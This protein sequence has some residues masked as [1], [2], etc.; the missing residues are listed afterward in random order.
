MITYDPA[1]FESD[2]AKAKSREEIRD[3]IL[4]TY[5]NPEYRANMRA[6][7]LTGTSV[8]EHTQ[9]YLAA[10]LQPKN[11]VGIDADATA[12]QLAQAHN[13]SL[14]LEYRMLESNLQ[15]QT[16][17]EHLKSNITPYDIISFDFDRNYGPVVSQ[18]IRDVFSYDADHLTD[19]AL[20]YVGMQAKRE[21]PRQ[22]WR[23]FALT[24]SL[25]ARLYF[26]TTKNVWRSSDHMLNTI[27]D[28]SKHELDSTGRNADRF[29]HILENANLTQPPQFEETPSVFRDALA[30]EMMLAAAKYELNTITKEKVQYEMQNDAASDAKLAVWEKL[31]A[32]S[33]NKSMDD[34]VLQIGAIY[35]ASVSAVGWTS[36]ER[37]QRLKT[38][39]GHDSKLVETLFPEIFEYGFEYIPTRLTP[40]SYVSQS[41]CRMQGMLAHY[42]KTDVTEFAQQLKMTLKNP[43]KKEYFWELQRILQAESKTTSG[44][45][46]KPSFV[47]NMPTLVQFHSEGKYAQKLSKG[48]NLKT[49]RTLIRHIGSIM[50]ELRPTLGLQVGEISHYANSFLADSIGLF[51]E[52][53]QVMI[54]E[55]LGAIYDSKTRLKNISKEERPELKTRD[56]LAELDTQMGT[57]GQYLQLYDMLPQNQRR[58]F[59]KMMRAKLE[60]PGQTNQSRP[61]IN[62]PSQVSMRTS[63]IP[64]SLT[65][66]LDESQFKPTQIQTQALGSHEDKINEPTHA[67]SQRIE[68]NTNSTPPSQIQQKQPQQIQQTQVQ[69]AHQ[70]KPTIDKA[71]F[72]AL[73]LS[74][75]AYEPIRQQ[76]NGSTAA[77][78][79]HIT[80]KTYEDPKK[81]P[82]LTA[83]AL[84]IFA[85]ESKPQDWAELGLNVSKLEEIVA[86]QKQFSTS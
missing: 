82:D 8:S 79:A 27:F 63:T 46:I 41:R 26:N 80:M 81:I 65:L 19:D 76:Y 54:K 78:E 16:I 83:A 40:I 30:A 44:E 37:Q 9:I 61:Q 70:T 24:T 3:V 31:Q 32:L 22:Q 67:G 52:H 58:D 45:N 51:P 75:V 6:L 18:S 84:D 86:L 25:W 73:R 4:Q 39:F 48:H 74:G 33:Y 2:P 13:A 20:F 55:E 77:W 35:M 43:K 7:F 85:N 72:L 1:Q 53:E 34:S 17:T 50:E 47:M 15:N 62:F 5:P 21:S 36:E 23:L 69:S 12:I 38:T 28:L 42:R 60:N 68:E 71:T 14:P 56:L 29:Y 64:R 57:T 49:F 66:R 10:G 59:D 11:I